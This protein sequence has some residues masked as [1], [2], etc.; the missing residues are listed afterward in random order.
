MTVKCMQLLHVLL[1]TQSR[2]FSSTTDMLL[3]TL[4]VLLYKLCTYKLSTKLYLWLQVYWN[5]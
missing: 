1:T 3:H 2:A 5:C 4:T